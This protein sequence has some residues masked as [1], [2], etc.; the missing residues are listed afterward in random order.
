MRRY[1]L[2]AGA[3]LVGGLAILLTWPGFRDLQA[4]S[5]RLLYVGRYI[6]QHGFA[7][8]WI[9]SAYGRG[10]AYA[11]QQWL[12]ELAAYEIWKLV[13]YAGLA[14]VSAG[15][16]GFGYALLTALIRRRGAALPLAIACAASAILASLS[17]TFVRA[18]LFAIPLFVALLWLCLDD[19]EQSCV[20]RRV[21]LVVPLLALWAN[22]H[23]SVLIGAGLAAAYFALRS[24]E[25]LRGGRWRGG[26][27]Y[28]ALAVACAASPLATPYGAGI[29]TYYAH[30]I[31]NH[32]VALADVEWG[33]PGFPTLA[34]FQFV[35]PLSLSIMA[36][37]PL[38]ARRRRGSLGAGRVRTPWILFA[39]VA[40]TAGA[41]WFAMRNNLWLAIVAAVLVG[42]AAKAWLPSGELRRGFVA[43]LWVAGIALLASA[44][45]HILERSS[46]AYMARAPVHAV[47]AAAAVA[48][49]EPCRLINGD[50]T[51]VSALLWLHP[52][53]TG[54]VAFDG[55]LE[56]YSEPALRRWV[57]FQA[58]RSSTSLADTGRSAI[59]IGATADQP[60]LVLRM[61]RLAASRVLA[62]DRQGVAVLAPAR[63]PGCER[64]AA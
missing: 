47:A 25:M 29:V 51:S 45:G 28:A 42:E 6:S 37:A 1:S 64:S 54:R 55:E 59:L 46:A 43:A 32:A 13:G 36:V 33:S 38:I 17:L 60:E 53:L 58:A 9:F 11:D 62:N 44:A 24:M 7:H 2:L 56:V 26:S 41:A 3:L 12:A 52:E 50:N 15:V 57:A 21:L 30:M 8:H 22:L 34:F 5:Y 19:S 49:A 31:G 10:R 18:Q 48:D 20:R 4:D 23:G 40:I 14:A 63:G 35:L 39:A 61:E 16:F 27:C